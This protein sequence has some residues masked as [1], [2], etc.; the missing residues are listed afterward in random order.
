MI[1][2]CVFLLKQIATREHRQ[3]IVLSIVDASKVRRL[4]E[5]TTISC[6]QNFSIRICVVTLLVSWY[7]NQT[8]QAEHLPLRR[9]QQNKNKIYGGKKLFWE[10][11][12]RCTGRH[13][14]GGRKKFALKITICPETNFFS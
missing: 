1:D 11:L 6:L 9:L 2:M 8:M 12:P 13:F 5:L 7:R 10:A 3:P 14:T 4:T